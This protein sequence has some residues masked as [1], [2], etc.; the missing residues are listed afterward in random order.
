[1]RFNPIPLITCCLLISFSTWAQTNSRH[2]L[3]LKSGTVTPV[4]NITPEEINTFNRNA[5][6]EQDKTFAVIQFEQIPTEAIRQ[7]LKQQGIE[8]LDYIPH[9]AFTVTITGSLNATA[10]LQANARSVIELS[11]TQKMQ[12]E[13]AKGNFPSYAVKVAGTVDVNISFPKSFSFEAVSAG[14][15]KMNFDIISLD[16]INYRLLTLRIPVQRLGELALLPYVEYVEPVHGEDVPLSQF[17][18]N[19]GRDGVRASQLSAPL[20][21]GGK[22][23]KGSGVVIGIGDNA[24][25]QPHVDFTNRVISRAGIGYSGHGTHVAGIAGGAGIRNEVRSGFAPKSTLI[26]QVYSNIFFNA[27]AYITDHG[28]VITNNSYGNNVSECATFGVYDLYS[29]VLDQQALDLPNL[30]NVFAAGNSGEKI[31]APFPDSFRT[32]LGGYQSAKNVI[33]VANAT[34]IG[35]IYQASSR[36]PV[37]DGRIKPDITAIGAWI[38]SAG[39][40]PFNYYWENQGTSMSAP[41]IS[42]GL[43]LLY[44][45]YRSQNAGANPKNGL[46]KALVCNS[47]DDWGMPGPDFTHGFGVAN[48]RRAVQMLE[49]NHFGTGNITNGNIEDEIN[50]SVPPGTAELKVM[51]YWN[52]P[53]PAPIASQALVNDLD[54]EVEE[55]S[56]AITLPFVLDTAFN[57]V[58]IAAHTGVDNINNIEQVVIKNPEAGA[59]IIRIKRSALPTGSQEYFIVYDLIP[60]ETILTA[61]FGGETYVHGENVIARWD[62]Y[63]DPQSTFTID[64]NDGIG[65]GWTTLKDNIESD[66][67]LYFYTTPNPNQWFIVPQVTTNN[68]QIRITRNTGALTNTSLPFVI[69]DTMNVSLSANQCEGYFSIDWQP[70]AGA[71]GYEVMM[72]QGD[73]MI[74]V[75]SVNNSTFTYTIGGLS[76][77]SVYWVTARPLINSVAIPT[78][79]PGRRGIAV[80]RKPDNGT[81][82]NPISNFD[83]KVDSILSPL[84]NGRLLTSTE[85][86]ASTPVSVRIKNLDD[87]PTTGNIEVTYTLSGAASATATETI[88]APNIPGGGT[89]VHVFAVANNINLSIAGTY[90]F[91]VIVTPLAVTD[92]I[93]QNNTLIQTYKQLPNPLISA[94]LTNINYPSPYVDN[95]DATSILSYTSDQVGMPGLDKYDFV[96]SNDDGRIR[97]FINT[98]I[99]YSGNR[100]LTLDA[101]VGNSG[102]TDS[103]TGTYNLSNFTASAHDLRLDFRYK[104]H[105]Q[106]NNAANKVWIRGQDNQNWIEAYDLFANQNEVGDGYKR[107]ASIEL[108]DLLNNAGQIFTPSFQIRW[109]QYG[110]HMAADDNGAAGYTFDDIR[111]YR[112]TD[113]MQMLSI[114]T[115]ATASCALT[116]ATQIKITVR[117]SSESPASVPVQFRINGGAWQPAIAENTP[118]IPAN[119]TIQYLFTATADLS[120]LGEHTIEARVLYASDIYPVNDTARL[121][122]LNLP[123]VVVTAS[124]PHLENFESG[125]GSWFSG[126][127][128]SSW[129]YGTPASFRINRAASGTKAWKTRISGNYNDLEKSYL[130]SPCFN[131]SSL[132]NPTLSFSVSLDFEDCGAV[133]LCDGAYMEYSLD[134]DTWDTLGAFGQGTNWYNKNYTSGVEL[135]SVQN[136]TRW[137]VA[138]I[139]LSVIPV[140]ASQLTQLRF[141]FVVI[142]DPFSNRDGLAVDDIHVYDNPYGIYDGMTMGAPQTANVLGNNAWVDFLSAGKLVASVKSPVQDMGSTAVQ[143][144]IH[145]GTPRISGLQ[146]YH[147]RN[148]TVKPT[149]LTL[150][151][152]ATV[153]FY[154]LDSET[155]TLI[156]ATGCAYCFKPSTAYDLGVTKYSDPDKIKENGT[157]ADNT[158]SPGIYHFII[159]PKVVKIPFDKGYYAEFKA[160]DFSEFWLNNGGLNQDRPLPVQLLSFTA[161]KT[162]NGKDVQA[163][164]ITVTEQNVNRY[165]IEVAKSNADYQQNRFVKIGE[166]NSIGNSTQEQRYNFTDIENGKI[167][168]RYYR[169]KMIDNDGSFTYSPIRPVIFNEEIQWQVNPNPSTGFFNFTCQVTDGELVTAKIYDISGKLVQT[170]QLIGNGFIQRINID[171]SEPKYASGLYL[172]EVVAGQKKQLFRLLKQQ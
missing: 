116:A 112:V 50:I 78:P 68:A 52:D 44:E 8:L 58:K 16:L 105:G 71:A 146:F 62:S 129:E 45:K 34:S 101:K 82:S 170:R 7:Q 93:L 134:G 128:N 20:S 4:Q 114:D 73:E 60:V 165:E 121:T 66:K 26:A 94:T 17:W 155:E 10:L 137:H 12:P 11:A 61:P 49:N 53:V 64:F 92:P 43:A 167:G 119:D 115:P 39:P 156:N 30:Q 96:N 77:D 100:A 74:S 120:A 130:Y 21:V 136:Y 163:E 1:M 42:G 148:I 111:L 87:V 79:S 22:N 104:N 157:L 132:T 169:L 81:C 147:N 149:T 166:V 65:G 108:S 107:T 144:Y 25:F 126:G 99:A 40:P 161:R 152:S 54:L 80:S 63:G 18:T 51:L 9:N 89:Y 95:F 97:T 29:R 83:I 84:K 131:V 38:T 88:I 85:L 127:K 31:C 150:S 145:T 159:S 23:L 72:L 13:L 171:L 102:T 106:G 75:A 103:L 138:T 117:N 48:F 37:R 90:T 2:N 15:R 57:L 133:T 3:L 67:R 162:A 140:P 123:V 56:T 153:R 28:M 164:W 139:P 160:N 5:Q 124:S 141:R 32:V 6:T 27:P 55:L 113:D 151:D 122:I 135:W 46:M 59:A 36:G 109:G 35:Y 125:N 154:F 143:A 41:A 76:K 69:S 168:T 24:D 33:S 98:G 19:W 91:E 158:N 14:L 118:A 70:V 86:N 110:T 172:M 47:G 142:S